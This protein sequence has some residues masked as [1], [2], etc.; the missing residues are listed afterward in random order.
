MFRLNR[1]HSRVVLIRTILVTVSLVFG[2]KSNAQNVGINATGAT[3]DASAI[4]DIVSTDKGLL[5]PRV[6]IGDVSLAA[7]I[8]SP[9]TSLLVYNTNAAITGGN[10]LGYYYWDGSQWVNL[11]TGAATSDD[12]TITGNAGTTAGTNFVGTTDAVDFVV[13]TNNTEVARFENSGGRVQF[14]NQ[15]SLGGT[16]TNANMFIR[17]DKSAYAPGLPTW[18]SYLKFSATDNMPLFGSSTWVESSGTSVYSINGSSSTAKYIGTGLLTNGYGGQ[19]YFSNT[20][21]GTVGFA[22][23]IRNDVENTSTGAIAEVITSSNMINNSGSTA[24]ISNAYGTE[25]EIKNNTGAIVDARLFKGVLNQSG[26]G[27][28]STVRGLDLSGWTNNGTVSNSYGI[29]MDNSIDVASIS[30]AIYSASNSNSHFAGKIGINTVSP[31]TLGSWFEVEDNSTSTTP[32]IE[33]DQN[34]SGDAAIKFSAGT[35][36]LAMGIDNSNS[37]KFIIYDG[38]TI[39]STSSLSRFT[40]E[41]NGD[42]GFGTN[43][44]THNV[45]IEESTTS[46]SPMLEIDQNSSGDGA[47]LFSA[48]S[49]SITLGIDNSDSDKFKIS[50]NTTL[51]TND[52]FVLTTAGNI[53]IGIGAPDAKFDVVSTGTGDFATVM[54]RA[55]T[56]TVNTSIV[57]YGFSLHGSNSSKASLAFKSTSDGYGRGDF[58]LLMDQASDWSEV[59]ETDEVMRFTHKGNICIGVS[60]TAGGLFTTNTVAIA[61]GVAPSGSIANGIQFYAEDVSSSSELKVRDE[62]G[63]VTTLSPHN[64]SIIPDGASEDLAWSLYS[65]N[66]AFGTAINVDM[67]KLAHLVEQLSGENLIYTAELENKEEG[68]SFSKINPVQKIKAPLVNQVEEQKQRIEKQQKQIEELTKRLQALEVNGN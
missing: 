33:L 26:S 1:S 34:G 47:M 30:Y 23:G 7:P 35:Q 49:Q 18:G 37:D 4:L 40:I 60:A 42:V 56:F 16:A 8:T 36:T 58:L 57:G 45:S 11:G 50:D 48:G 61:N 53:G 6:S 39:G 59:A 3:P 5:I 25:N 44:P 17:L 43:N 66:H 22:F 31:S 13:K 24:F 46:T 55:S 52:R 51:G 15:I 41:T 29:Y 67:L 20:T 27:T 64:F 21:S 54:V 62:A 10:G 9:A 14:Q 63:N 2:L 12:W 65:E 32:F 28:T 38:T 19:N 68:G